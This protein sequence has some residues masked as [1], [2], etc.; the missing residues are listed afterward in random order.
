V[1]RLS[2][3]VLEHGLCNGALYLF[4]RLLGRVSKQHI[5]L[6]KYYFVAQPVASEIKAPAAGGTLN[7][8]QVDATHPVT[9]AFPRP[10]EVIARRFRDGARCFVAFRG[11]EFAGFL[12]LQEGRYIEDEVRCIY[13]PTPKHLAAWDYDVYV[14]PQFRL[15]RTFARLWESA[16]EYLRE[17][18]YKWTMSRISAFNRQSLASHQKL[19]AVVL[20]SGVFLV[21]AR[22]QIGFFS[23]RPFVHVSLTK[24]T[25]PKIALRT[26]GASE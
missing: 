11:N 20:G 26:T 8:V 16:H 24:H 3:F 17:R 23:M 9:Q 1:K 21:I 19:G 5:R 18:G 12:W 15:S 7:V 22:W 14:E 13:C 4:A 2:A 6:L 10:P 25:V